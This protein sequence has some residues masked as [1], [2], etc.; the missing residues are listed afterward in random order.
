MNGAR[1]DY[2]ACNLGDALDFAFD[3][4]ELRIRARERTS[5]NKRRENSRPRGKLQGFGHPE[6]QR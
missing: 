1:S 6:K 2:A 3:A 5:E 4:G